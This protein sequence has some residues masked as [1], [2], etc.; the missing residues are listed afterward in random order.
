MYR[1][2]TYFMNT[3]YTIYYIILFY[4][5]LFNDNI[6]NYKF[7]NFYHLHTLLNEIVLN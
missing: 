6:Q 4:E 5:Y 2:D 3:I 7:I 1:Y